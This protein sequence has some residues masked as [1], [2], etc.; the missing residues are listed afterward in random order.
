VDFS[1]LSHPDLDC[2]GAGE[3]GRVD[4][5]RKVSADLTGD[6]LPEAVVVVQCAHA[7]SEWPHSAYVYSDATGQPTLIGTLVRQGNENYVTGVRASGHTVTLTLRGWS[8]YAAGCCPDLVFRQVFTWTGST[9]SAGSRTDV[10]HPCDGQGDALPISVVDDGGATGHAAITLVWRNRLPQSCTLT[11]FPG[12]DGE[13]SGGPTVHAA[14][15]G[16][17]FQPVTLAP[18]GY[19]SALLE[20]ATIGSDGGSCVASSTDLLVTPPNTNAT[21][22]LAQHVG[23]CSLQIHP[24]VS[25]RE[26]T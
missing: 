16:V 19:A 14:R 7:A 24:V 26:G 25:G 2:S 11:G 8:L 18:G 5:V 21:Q 3:G 1:R 10:L 17:P 23:L 12:V 4:V 9:F 20:W 15:A 22:T 6:G 13:Q